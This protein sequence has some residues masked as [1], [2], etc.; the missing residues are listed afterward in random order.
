MLFNQMDQIINEPTHFPRENIE[1]C[2]DLILTNQ[3]NLFVHSG[4]IQSPDL[5]C[6]HQ[7][8]HGTLNFSIPCPPPYKRKLWSYSKANTNKIKEN[9]NAINWNE[10]LDNKSV[11]EMVTS[12]NKTFLDIINC[13][14]PNKEATIN[15]KDAPW[16]TA[17]VK[18]AIKKKHRVF[19]KWKKAGKPDSG[20]DIVKAVNEDT[21]KKNRNR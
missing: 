11:D 21:D 18:Q 15:D 3:P 1:T 7:I 5:N 6:K 9:L 13:N 16:I 12:F 4:V 8:I 20:K 14:I 10:Y 19:S 2:I 17:E